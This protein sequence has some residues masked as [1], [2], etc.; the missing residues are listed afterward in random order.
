MITISYRVFANKLAMDMVLDVMAERGYTVS[1]H[2]I[3][4]HVPVKFDTKTGEITSNMVTSYMFKV[5][6]KKSRIRDDQ[7]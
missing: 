1:G 2:T 4:E 3:D 6:F 7:E 5:K